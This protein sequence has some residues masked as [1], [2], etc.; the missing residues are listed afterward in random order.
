MIYFRARYTGAGGPWERWGIGGCTPDPTSN[1]ILSS[2]NSRWT[3]RL[4]TVSLPAARWHRYG[5]PVAHGNGPECDQGRH[6]RGQRR[7]EHGFECDESPEAFLSDTESGQGS[8]RRWRN[9]NRGDQAERSAACERAFRHPPQAQRRAGNRGH[10][11]RAHLAAREWCLDQ[12]GDQRQEEG[13]SD[14]ITGDALLSP[15]RHG[16]GA[17]EHEG[18]N[19]PVEDQIDDERSNALVEE[20]AL[21][22]G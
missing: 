16:R 4:S 15:Q 7:G 22:R 2:S 9:G 12:A 17:A 14:G 21:V 3:F 13:R 6:H 18:G 10:P 5:L 11:A 1:T 8:Y 20:E 19:K